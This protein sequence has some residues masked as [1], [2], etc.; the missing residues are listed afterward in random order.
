MSAMSE[1]RHSRRRWNLARESRIITRASLA[2]W[3]H[4][5][6]PASAPG[7]QSAQPRASRRHEAAARIPRSGR[8]SAGMAS[9]VPSA[10]PHHSLPLR[11]RASLLPGALRPPT[12][13][14]ERWGDH[15]FTL[16]SVGNP[17]GRKAVSVLPFD[18]RLDRKFTFCVRSRQFAKGSAKWRISTE[19]AEPV[20]GGRFRAQRWV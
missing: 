13:N 19:K 18:L 14:E 9:H 4:L 10:R 8:K 6:V 1:P 5:C 3:P 2:P 16:D 20:S 12:N 17:E 15:S 7:S 11:G